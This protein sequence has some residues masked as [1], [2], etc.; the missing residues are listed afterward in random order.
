MKSKLVD[1]DWTN[2][3]VAKSSN[4]KKQMSMKISAILI[5]NKS[6]TKKVTIVN[7]SMKYIL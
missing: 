3:L 2:Q 7:I 1:P 5:I 4:L 6:K